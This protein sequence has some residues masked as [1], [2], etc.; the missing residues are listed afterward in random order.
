METI[1]ANVM[2]VS[3]NELRML[4]SAS[5]LVF[6][7]YRVRLR[8]GQG[9]AGVV[10]QNAV[11]G[12]I[13]DCWKPVY[14]TRAQLTAKLQK[15]KWRLTD[16][17]ILQTSHILWILSIPLFARKQ[18]QRTFL[19]VLNYD[20]VHKP[21]KRPGRLSQSDFV[22]ECVAMGERMAEVVSGQGAL[23]LGQIDVRP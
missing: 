14:I 2:V 20:G 22:G 11:E 9:C 1:R 19:G 4:A 21:L 12:P 17:Q 23:L 7:D 6:P 16:E 3:G 13:N 5:M 10:W 8:K 15:E 18:G